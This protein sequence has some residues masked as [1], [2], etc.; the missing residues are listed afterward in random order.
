MKLSMRPPHSV[1]LRL[2]IWNV[3]IFALV[4]LGMGAASHYVLQRSLLNALDRQMATRAASVIR[5]MDQAP[6]GGRGQAAGE[7]AATERREREQAAAPGQAGRRD[8]TL[9]AYLYRPKVLMPD[10]R[11]SYFDQTPDQPWDHLAFIRSLNGETVRANIVIE[12]DPYRILSLPV[13]RGGRVQ[14][15][16]QLARPL[17]D[18]QDALQAST[19]TLLRLLPVALLLSGLVGLFLTS[20]A[21]LP[22]RRLRE[23]ADRIQAENL[24]QRLP[25]PGSDEFSELAHTFNE[26]L[27]RLERAFRQQARFT[28]DASH[29]L[30]TPLTVLRGNVS[31]ALGRQRSPQEY[32]ETLERVQHAAGQMSGLVEDLLLLARADAGQLLVDAQPVAL[33]EVL[34][35]AVAA[36]PGREVGVAGLPTDAPLTLRGNQGLL[37]TLFANLLRNADRHTPAGGSVS[38]QVQCRPGQ[39]AVT[40][41]DTGQ[42]IAP[43]HLPHVLERFYRV[44]DARSSDAGGTGLG[45]AICQSIAEAHG[46][47]IEVASRPGRG[48]QVTV[49]LPLA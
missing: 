13:Q 40:V 33:G 1:R 31:L 14:A 47:S 16:V 28:A 36:V 49:A 32:R 12:D 26:L 18:I 11:S 21:L 4:L 24:S 19:R 25:V 39:V 3:G 6:A 5:R 27:D 46:G 43:E 35:G 30:R 9:T 15:V 17:G 20:R 37:T 22:V 8:N 42:G 7:S 45:L 48:T 41:A 34:A 23:A 10:G 38:L 29:E 2:A 44:D